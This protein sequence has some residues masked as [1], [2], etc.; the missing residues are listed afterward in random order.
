MHKVANKLQMNFVDFRK[1][2]ILIKVVE[3]D[4]YICCENVIEIEFLFVDFL[5]F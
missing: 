2:I 5:L 3:V 1:L 4:L